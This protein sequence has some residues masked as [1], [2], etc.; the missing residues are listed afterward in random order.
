MGHGNSWGT[1]RQAGGIGSLAGGMSLAVG[2]PMRALVLFLCIGCGVTGI[3]GPDGGS[4]GGS[5]GTGGG[6]AGGG[7]TGGGSAGGGSAGGTAGGSSGGGSAGGTGGSGGGS[8]SGCSGL[9]E[10]TCRLRPGCVAERCFTCSC[11]PSYNGCRGINEAQLACP[12]V[13]C[14][15]PQCCRAQSACTNGGVC[16]PQGTPHSCGACNIDP[17]DCTEDSTCGAGDICAPIA[18]SCNSAQ[19]CTAG[20]N[21]DQNCPDGQ[22]CSNGAHPRCVPKQCATP[23]D[24][25]PGFDCQAAMCVR[26]SCNVDLDCGPADAAFCVL[27]TCYRGLGECRLPVP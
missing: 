16:A 2:P 27:G 24:C 5:S 17:G 9:D 23:S 1:A 15:T 12:L 25:G 20:C 22:R 11:T 13:D 21:S 6:S 4:G 10:T 18:C 19:R 7:S 8:S 14:I 26:R 3:P